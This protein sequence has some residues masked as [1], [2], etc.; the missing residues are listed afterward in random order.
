M[1]LTWGADAVACL[2]MMKSA[3][4]V[5]RIEGTEK[6]QRKV[7]NT[8]YVNN[9]Q[10]NMVL[11]TLSSAALGFG[12]QAWQILGCRI[13]RGKGREEEILPPAPAATYHYSL[14]WS[15]GV[16]Y[17]A[18][19]CRTVAVMC[20]YWRSTYPLYQLRIEPIPR[21]LNTQQHNS[22]IVDCCLQ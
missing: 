7:S 2:P 9:N 21:M 3:A 20:C 22:I 10:L 14:S 18:A 13:N 1:D 8:F 4:L 6:N 19:D 12:V 16:R 5:S 15:R 11:L 17:F